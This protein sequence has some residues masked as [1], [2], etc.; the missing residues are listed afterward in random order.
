MLHNTLDHIAFPKGHWVLRVPCFS[1]FRGTQLADTCCQGPLGRSN[2][3]RILQGCYRVTQ[4]HSSQE[5]HLH[6]STSSASCRLTWSATVLWR[7]SLT[8]L[9]S[10]HSGFLFQHQN[11]FF[12]IYIGCLCVLSCEELKES[13][14]ISRG[15]IAAPLSKWRA[16]RCTHSLSFAKIS[17]ASKCC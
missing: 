7:S 12:H 16:T 14:S 15:V 11:V 17:C 9:P 4:Q 6:L 13:K 10:A 3:R 8:R 5:L 2:F 1:P